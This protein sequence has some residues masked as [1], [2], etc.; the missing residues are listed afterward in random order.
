M[1]CLSDKGQE[2][3]YITRAAAVKKRFQIAGIRL[4]EKRRAALSA[5]EFNIYLSFVSHPFNPPVIFSLLERQFYKKILQTL[6]FVN[7]ASV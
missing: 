5:G 7:R 1:N 2:I 6:R 4:P 3:S